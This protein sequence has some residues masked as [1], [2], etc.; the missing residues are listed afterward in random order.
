MG[1]LKLLAVLVGLLRSRASGRRHGGRGKF[2]YHWRRTPHR[3]M[4]WVLLMM[5]VG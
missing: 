3:R 4:H 5:N 2:R 1:L